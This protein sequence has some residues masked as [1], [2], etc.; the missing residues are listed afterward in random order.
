MNNIYISPKYYHS[1]AHTFSPAVMNSLINVG[2]SGYLSE[3]LS[4]S[5]LLNSIDNRMNMRDFFE[6][7]YWFLSNTYRNEYIY[8]N[9]I[10]N[11]I[12]LGRHS[13]NSSSMLTEFRVGDC[14]ADVVIL[15]NTSTVYEIK[16]E[17]DSLERLEEQVHSY[18]QMFEKINV[19]SSSSHI[20]KLENILPLEIGILELTN[21]NKIHT[22][23]EAISG[24][25]SIVPAVIFNSLRKPEYID[26]VKR[27]FGYVPDVPNT[28]IFNECFKLFT[29][30]S[31]EVAHE[32]MIR[33]LH[34]RRNRTS[35]SGC[36]H[37]IPFSLR[38]YIIGSRVNYSS[39]V[40]LF[41]LLETKLE[42][43]LVPVS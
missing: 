6:Y 24:K 35:L 41:T 10:T 16:S 33:T 3:I 28:R 23:R 25:Q 13:L 20:S 4:T 9:V 1:L 5:G 12:L 32:E 8:K 38:A 31:P 36:I 14:K 43:A 2:Y 19:I 40:R 7:L 21:N 39:I 11:K 26:I 34:K 37:D 30:L 15:N 29:T 22:V 27:R 42:T 17:Y 18:M